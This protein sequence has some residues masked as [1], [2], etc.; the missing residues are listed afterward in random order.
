MGFLGNGTNIG[1]AVG[2]AVARGNQSLTKNKV[3]ILLTDGV[4]NVGNMTPH[5]G[6]QSGPD[7]ANMKVYTIASG[8]NKGCKD[9][10]VARDGSGESPLSQHP[11]RQYR[12]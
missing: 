6:R 11:R 10:Q 2:L 5:G 9:A 1:D 8:K 4:S 7:Q 3:V 12:S